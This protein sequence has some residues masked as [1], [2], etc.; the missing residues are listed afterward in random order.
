MLSVLLLAFY[1]TVAELHMSVY[2]YIYIYIYIYLSAF[3]IYIFGLLTC[4]ADLG[5]NQ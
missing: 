5:L 4:S 1:K 2:I 3:R